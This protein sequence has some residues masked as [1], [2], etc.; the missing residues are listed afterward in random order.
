M[1]LP[2]TGYLQL[3]GE[4]IKSPEDAKL[5]IDFGLIKKNSGSS[6]NTFEMWNSLTRVNKPYP[7]GGENQEI[8]CIQT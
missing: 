4:L 5:L 6:Q 2:C 1:A 7:S 8:V 3:I